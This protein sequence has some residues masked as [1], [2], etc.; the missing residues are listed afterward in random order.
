MG[1][2]FK[3]EAGT[4]IAGI[5]ISIGLSLTVVLPVLLIDVLFKLLG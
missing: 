2:F 1:E 5:V 3:S 4:T